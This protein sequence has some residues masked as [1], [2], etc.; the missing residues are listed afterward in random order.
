MKK[1]PITARAYAERLYM[2]DKSTG[3]AELCQDTVI[4]H[5][6]VNAFIDG[7]NWAKRQAS[8]GRR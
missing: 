4:I 7:V 6:R 2:L 1:K 8:K 3:K 5:S